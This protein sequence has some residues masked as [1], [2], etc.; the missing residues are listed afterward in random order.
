MVRGSLDAWLEKYRL[1]HRKESYN[2][3]K[4]TLHEFFGHE[5]PNGAWVRGHCGA[6]T[7]EQ[8]RRVDLLRYRAWCIDDK[9]R[10]A[11]TAANKML[12]VNQFVRSGLFSSAI[13]LFVDSLQKLPVPVVTLNDVERI[14][15]RGFSDEQFSSVITLLKEYGTEAWHR[16]CP[17]VQLAALKLADGSLEKLRAQIETAKR[18]YRDVVAVAEFPAYC[19]V[20]FSRIRKLPVDERLRIIKADWSQYD[21]WLRK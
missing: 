18:D 14:A 17:R 16:E 3:M 5:Q 20:G 19:K 10:S 15:R 8:V 7:V 13:I 12:R 1:S 21:E 11:R 2:L 4:Q 6:A 9:K